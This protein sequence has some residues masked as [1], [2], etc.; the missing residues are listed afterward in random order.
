MIMTLLFANKLCVVLLAQW[1]YTCTTHTASFTSVNE[2]LCEDN[3]SRDTKWW[4][5]RKSEGRKV[6]NC[7]ILLHTQFLYFCQTVSNWSQRSARAP[8]SLFIIWIQIWFNICTIAP[9]QR[10]RANERCRWWWWW[11]SL[12]GHRLAPPANEIHLLIIYWFESDCF[13]VCLSALALTLR[14]D[15]SVVHSDSLG[16]SLDAHR[17]TS[18]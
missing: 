15:P 1:Q 4:R 10:V 17:C 18:V 12:T 8:T 16:N 11:W 6:L 7:H 13:S 5:E 9:A 2:R 14:S 3:K